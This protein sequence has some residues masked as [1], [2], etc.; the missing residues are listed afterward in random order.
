MEPLHR[1]P[2]APAKVNA[3]LRRQR[4]LDLRKVGGSYRKIAEKLGV[5]YETVRKDLNTSLAELSEEEQRKAAECRA[6]DLMRLDMSLNSIARLV[7]EG[8]LG[9]I[10]RWH[11]NIEVRMKILGYAAPEKRAVEMTG[12]LVGLSDEDLQRRAREITAAI[13]AAQSAEEAGADE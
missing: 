1:M 5:S 3:A 12:G 11:R 7:A 6:L 13:E 8:H 10:D 9:A 2:N 4:V